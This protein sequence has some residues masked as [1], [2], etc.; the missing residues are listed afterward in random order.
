MKDLTYLG[1][2]N[3]T[4]HS[5]LRSPRVSSNWM[6]FIP[7]TITGIM[8]FPPSE[9]NR[10]LVKNEIIK[11]NNAVNL[12]LTKSP[13]EDDERE[14]EREEENEKHAEIS[15]AEINEERDCEPTKNNSSLLT[16]KNRGR[17]E[18][19][20]IL[21]KINTKINNE[22]GKNASNSAVINALKLETNDD[23][24]K[25]DEDRKVEKVGKDDIKISTDRSIATAT[26]VSTVQT[27]G[28]IV[29]T[30]RAT[31]TTTTAAAV[32]IEE[33]VATSS[34]E[35]SDSNSNNI[36]RDPEHISV[37]NISPQ[38]S[39]SENNNKEIEKEIEKT[40][41]KDKELTDSYEDSSGLN[42][43]P[44]N[45]PITNQ[46]HVHCVSR[47][48]TEAGEE[49][50]EGEKEEGEEKDRIFGYELEK[51]NF[52]T[53]VPC[54]E[55][56]EE[57]CSPQSACNASNTDS[58]NSDGDTM[59]LNDNMNSTI[60]DNDNNIEDVIDSEE[61]SDIKNVEI[62]SQNFV[63]KSSNFSTEEAGLISNK[64]IFDED[65]SDKNDIKSSSDENQS[66]N[67]S[68]N[69]IKSNYEYSEPR[70]PILSNRPSN[71]TPRNRHSL[72][73]YL[74]NTNKNNK[75]DYEN[76]DLLDQGIK[77]EKNYKIDN[78]N[79]GENRENGTFNFQDLSLRISPVNVNKTENIIDEDC[80]I[81]KTL[82]LINSKIDN[83]N[84]IPQK[85]T[86]KNDN[87]SKTIDKKN[88]LKNNLIG[89]GNGR[90]SKSY[91]NRRES[92]RRK[93][94]ESLNITHAFKLYLTEKGHRIP[95]FL[96]NRASSL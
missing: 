8:K 1:V 79:N 55:E 7:E 62:S 61:I 36:H 12:N 66:E 74:N 13:S 78:T 83:K 32:I 52:L 6:F 4:N 86:C 23:S 93:E 46:E 14:D 40:M 26:A 42:M 5:P 69:D 80:I 92:D 64:N 90:E 15:T 94:L 63:K 41:E 34:I 49:E 31:A 95:L 89:S 11:F 18:K 87:K 29:T 71:L 59:C 70:P 68:E 21:Q 96:K 75:L 10:V 91:G 44:S 53:N 88:N 43:I 85:I 73:Y 33:L 72:K 17:K 65:S 54:M 3:E 19:K 81:E 48:T 20:S 22:V 28:R 56:V 39:N 16:E 76:L 50:E 57:E 51:S 37:D 25:D 58:N 35:T 38:G 84:R 82:P 77:I 27:T 60:D 9:I 67:E 45:T 47:H 30:A 2:R 24:L